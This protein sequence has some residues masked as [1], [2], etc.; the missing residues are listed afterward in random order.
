MGMV[1]AAIIPIGCVINVTGFFLYYW[2]LKYNLVNYRKTPN[3]QSNKLVTEM[4]E[5]IEM[6]E[7]GLI[8]YS[9]S[10]FLF[11][12]FIMEK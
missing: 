7:F 4:I 11:I 12:Y 9:F 1:Y 2:A 3:S 10:N 8:L 5:M 6:I